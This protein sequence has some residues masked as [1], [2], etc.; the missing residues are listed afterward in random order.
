MSVLSQTCLGEPS[1]EMAFIRLERK[2]RAAY[3]ENLEKAHDVCAHVVE[4]CRQSAQKVMCTGR[5]QAPDW[6]FSLSLEV[7]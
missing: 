4:H 6:L 3:E 5:W 2:F 1:R 7:K